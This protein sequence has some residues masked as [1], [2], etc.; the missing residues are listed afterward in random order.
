MKVFS[1]WDSS[2]TH[3]LPL[4]SGG[5]YQMGSHGTSW[6]LAHSFLLGQ[7]TFL[8]ISCTHNSYFCQG[9]R[10]TGHDQGISWFSRF[11]CPAVPYQT[12]TTESS[13]PR[14]SPWPYFTHITL[15]TARPL[16]SSPP[17]WG[18]TSSGNV[19]E[20]FVRWGLSTAETPAQSEYFLSQHDFLV[21]SCL[22]W[23]LLLQRWRWYC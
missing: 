16:Q 22:R 7:Q 3:L 9:P 4:Q 14:G 13:S 23:L 6:G 17:M 11:S 8:E 20:G 12:W 15:T 21:A 18:P 19:P 2:L 5:Q 1:S 10:Q